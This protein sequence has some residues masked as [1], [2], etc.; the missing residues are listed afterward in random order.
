MMRNEFTKTTIV[1]FAIGNLVLTAHV[2]RGKDVWADIVTPGGPT[3]SAD[4]AAIRAAMDY[5]PTRPVRVGVVDVNRNRPEVR[6]HLLTL[7][8]FTVPGNNVIYIVQ[9]SQALAAARS[10]S[11][12]FRAMLASILWHEMAHLKGSNERE[13]R[14][15]EQE[16]WQRFI[17]DGVTDQLTA[18]RYLDALRRRP[19]DQFPAPR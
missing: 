2:A 4:E 14:K 8:A 18:L 3:A 1:L 9:Q 19:D 6:A 13:A 11:P 7:D 12:L 16:I 5:L 10:G 17:R 15:A